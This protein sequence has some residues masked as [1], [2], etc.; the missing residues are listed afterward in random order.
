MVQNGFGM[1][2][3]MAHS[4]EM[5]LTPSCDTLENVKALSNLEE[6]MAQECSKYGSRMISKI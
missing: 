6:T 5:S 4:L 1:V 3:N 2:P